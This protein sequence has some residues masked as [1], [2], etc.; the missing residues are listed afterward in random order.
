MMFRFLSLLL[1]FFSSLHLSANNAYFI[2]KQV[3]LPELRASLTQARHEKSGVK[4]VH[5]HAPHEIENFFCIAF[6]TLPSSSNGVAHIL[7]H[8]VLEGSEKFPARGLFTLLKERSCATYLNAFTTAD[9]TCYVAASLIPKDFYNIFEVYLDAVFNP[10]ITPFAFAQEGFRKEVAGSGGIEYKGV[11]YNEMKGALASPQ[12][13]LRRT[14]YEELFPNTLYRFESGGDPAL[15]PQISLEEV[16]SFHKTYYQPSNCLLFLYGDIPFEEHMEFL[17]QHLP[18]N[19]EEELMLAVPMQEPLAE[20]VRKECGEKGD[21]RMVGFGWLTAPI[22]QAKEAAALLLIDTCLMGSDRGLL[23]QKLLKSGLCAEARTQLDDWKV[24]M[25]YFL[26]AERCKKECVDQLEAVL[27]ESLKNIVEEGIP[28]SEIQNALHLHKVHLSETRTSGEPFGMTLFERS[29]LFQMAG[30]AI[31]EALLAKEVLNDLQS[32]LEREPRFLENLINRYLILNPHF[33]RISFDPKTPIPSIHPTLSSDEKES[34]LEQQKKLEVYQNSTIENSPI[35]FLAPDEVALKNSTPFQKRMWNGQT[36]YCLP[37]FTNGVTHADLIFELPPM[38]ELWIAQLFCQLA[39]ELGTQDLSWQEMLQYVHQHTSGVSAAPFV[40]N[41]S[42]YLALSAKAF[43]REKLIEILSKLATDL[44]FEDKERIAD[45]I[46]KIAARTKNS[47]ERNALAYC[48]FAATKQ[49]SMQGYVL[50]EWHG[51]EYTKKL[52]ALREALDDELEGVLA[53]L[54]A[55]YKGLLHGLFVLVSDQEEY[56]HFMS[57]SS[58]AASELLPKKYEVPLPEKPSSRI[59]EIASPVAFN[60]VGFMSVP[61]LQKESASLSIA[62]A[63]MSKTLHTHIRERGGAY[64]GRA[65]YD[66]SSGHFLFYSYRDPHIAKTFNAFEQAIQEIL[67]GT[68]SFLDLEEAKLKVLQKLQ[69]PVPVSTLGL[70]QLK[71]TLEGKTE[72]VIQSFR[73]FVLKCDR[74]SIIQVVRKLIV[75]GYAQ[76]SFVTFAGKT[77]LENNVL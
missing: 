28:Q 59:E 41:G 52:E 75:E 21:E 76:G 14:L 51:L 26:V 35:A 68:F 29:G 9:A 55:F 19:Q 45:C 12:A 6:R 40:A 54:Q 44:N 38:E 66:F 42:L 73:D 22:L 18:K 74:E 24:Q 72:Q 5:I 70:K 58:D 3:E 16:R 31:D 71:E 60:A 32:T 69:A 2:E 67:Q 17:D 13:R 11:V 39:P 53:K 23:K 48:L 64:G 1:Y 62:A 7:E 33:V 20:P 46:K 34:V 65:S 30:G 50:N 57:I 61:F 15:I 10:L 63:L 8:V 36:F 37:A 25:P 43:S 47:I 77:L 4:I 56:E 49:A 27:F